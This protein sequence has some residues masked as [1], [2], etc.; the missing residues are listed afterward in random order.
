MLSIIPLN[1]PIP[2]S[3]PVLF[4]TGGMALVTSVIMLMVG[5]ARLARPAPAPFKTSLL[6]TPLACS[7]KTLATLGFSVFGKLSLV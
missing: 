2:A 3:T 1:F 6:V 5:T 4:A 7:G